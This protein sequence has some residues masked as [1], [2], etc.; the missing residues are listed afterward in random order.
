MRMY[1]LS[2][3]ML[4]LYIAFNK[5]AKINVIIKKTFDSDISCYQINNVTLNLIWMI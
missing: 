1:H 2:N 4:S 3:T 5:K